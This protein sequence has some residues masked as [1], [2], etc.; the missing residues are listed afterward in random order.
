LGIARAGTGYG[1]DGTIWGGEFLYVTDGA[2]TGNAA[3]GNAAIGAPC[4][5]VAHLRP[6]RLP[7]GDQAIKEPRRAALG[8]LYELF[9]DEVF[10]M[11]SLPLM[12]AFLKPELGT[13]KTMLNRN[14]NT[15][16][17]SSAGRLFDAVAALIGLCQPTQPIQ[18]EGQAAMALE[19]ALEASDQSYGFD[20]L[21]SQDTS[22][23][24]VIDWA[25]MVREI[26]AD[27]DTGMAIAKLSVKFHNTLVEMMVAVAKRFG[28]E[29]IVLTGGCFQNQYLTERA[30]NRLSAAGFTPYWHQ[31][32]PPNDGGIALG[33]IRAAL[34]VLSRGNNL[35]A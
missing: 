2:A 1:P 6:F 33:Q 3:T 7:G 20:L 15:P 8:L 35:C 34:H 16:V 23:P 31:H 24:M 14:L 27:L 32:L 18:F 28:E 13:L 22:S 9:G 11:R 5:R 25:A 12:Q 29:R 4:Q 21:A 26:L 30:I 17:T 19:F 10:E